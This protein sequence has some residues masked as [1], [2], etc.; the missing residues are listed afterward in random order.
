M[1][2]YCTLR[3][4][5]NDLASDVTMTGAYRWSRVGTFAGDMDQIVVNTQFLPK[6]KGLRRC[7]RRWMPAAGL[8]TSTVGTA[9]VRT[10]AELVK[11]AKP[12]RPKGYS[13]DKRGTWLHVSSNGVIDARHA[14]YAESLVPDGKKGSWLHVASKDNPDSL[15]VLSVDGAMVAIVACLLEPPDWPGND[16]YERTAT[17]LLADLLNA[18][19]DLALAFVELVCRTGIAAFTPGQLTP[20]ERHGN[21]I[22]DLTIRDEGNVIR[23]LVENK[24]WAQLGPAQPVDYLSTLPADVPSALVF[25]VPERRVDDLWNELREK[26]RKAVELTSETRTDT[27]TWTRSGH[28]T[29]A[30]TSW[31][32]VAETLEHA[33][34][35]DQGRADGG[36]AGEHSALQQNLVQFRRLI[37]F[38]DGSATVQGRLQWPRR[39]RGRKR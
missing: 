3:E 2:E 7:L 9:F 38:H 17:K 6:G 26:C 1:G 23:I 36:G 16:V 10:M 22:P 8:K 24:F 19:P 32:H 14:A 28:R 27:I 29:L 21:I 39:L 25:V 11:T 12:H 18:S 31:K 15:A 5:R 4:R 30:I 20:E 13:R 33:G 37:D 34:P 35:R